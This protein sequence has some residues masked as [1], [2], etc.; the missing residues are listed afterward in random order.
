VVDW[1]KEYEK[2]KGIGLAEAMQAVMLPVKVSCLRKQEQVLPTKET[3][4]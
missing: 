2:T 1:A 3:S 4:T